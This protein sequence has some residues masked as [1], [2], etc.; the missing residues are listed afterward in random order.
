MDVVSVK[1][2]DTTASVNGEVHSQSGNSSMHVRWR[3][4]VSESFCAKHGHVSD[5]ASNTDESFGL[6]RD[7]RLGPIF[8]GLLFDSRPN[9]L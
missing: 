8:V 3:A 6:L 4:C 1:D 2:G 9:E 5:F 7:F